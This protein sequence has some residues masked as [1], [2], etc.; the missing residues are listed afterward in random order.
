MTPVLRVRTSWQPMIAVVCEVVKVWFMGIF[1]V[2]SSVDLSGY[3]VYEV[4]V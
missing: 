3:Y 1:I 4:V 2:K